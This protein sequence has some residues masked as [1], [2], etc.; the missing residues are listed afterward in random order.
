LVER[1]PEINPS[2]VLKK[3]PF[4]SSMGSFFCAVFKKRQIGNK[5]DNPYC[6]PDNE[7]FPPIM[8]I[9]NEVS[10]SVSQS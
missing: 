7:E 6:L 1:F 9:L 3:L 10:G 2:C 8:T 4:E 5:A